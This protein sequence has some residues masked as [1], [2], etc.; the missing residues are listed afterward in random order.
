MPPTP[1]P[2]RRYSDAELTDEALAAAGVDVTGLPA[3]P[4]TAN[5]R[6]R[7]VIAAV[8]ALVAVYAVPNVAR[9]AAGTVTGSSDDTASATAAAGK[10]A[11]PNQADRFAAQATLS[12]QLTAA[13]TWR[14]THGT[15]DGFSADGVTVI[16]GSD[17][18]VLITRV[19]G[20]C[21]YIGG[22]QALNLQAV[23]DEGACTRA[24]QNKWAQQMRSAGSPANAFAHAQAEQARAAADVQAQIDQFY[25]R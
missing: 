15:Y 9:L 2:S 22:P 17:S 20:R 6:R 25:G 3:L 7:L 21:W 23:L 12:K 18:V 19:D 13:T 4:P 16:G 8:A 14:V 1:D 10:P 11:E 24:R 5:R